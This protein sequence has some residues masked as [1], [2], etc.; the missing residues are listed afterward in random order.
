[1]ITVAD[2]LHVIQPAIARAV[3]ALDSLP[4]QQ[5]VRRCVQAGAQVLDL[6]PGPLNKEPETKMTFLVESVQAVTDL[7]LSLDTTNAAALAAG[8]AKCRRRAII[9]GFSLEPAKIERILPL[10]QRYPA[11]IIGYLL[12]PDSR[13]PVETDEMMSVAVAL[14][15]VYVRAGLDPRHLI[16]DPIIA[17]LSWQEGI[18]HNRAVLKVIAGL[19]DLLGTPVRTIAGLSNLATGPIPLQRKIELEQTFLPMLASAGLDMVL[20]DVLHGPTLETARRCDRLLGDGVF[21]FG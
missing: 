3:E 6:N 17:P 20:L 12:H 2:N 14:F 15:D 11:D 18:R 10:A 13:V 9:N 7:P 4:I 16:I 19:D 8:L 1:M 5:L 21:A